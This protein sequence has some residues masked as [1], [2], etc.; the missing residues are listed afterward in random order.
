MCMCVGEGGGAIVEEQ[1][2]NVE[3]FLGA[4]LL[5]NQQ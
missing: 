2:I 1:S 5:W 4:V 3:I